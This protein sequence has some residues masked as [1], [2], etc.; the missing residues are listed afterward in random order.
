MYAGVDLMDP[1][2]MENFCKGRTHVKG[3]RIPL[4]ATVGFLDLPMS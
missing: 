3:V 4:L 2:I 1:D